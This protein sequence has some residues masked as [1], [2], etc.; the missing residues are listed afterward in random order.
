MMISTTPE[1]DNINPMKLNI[2]NRSFNILYAKIG[3]RTGIMD[4]ITAAIV[5]ETCCIP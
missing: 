4:I 2:F 5:G 3:V 1:K